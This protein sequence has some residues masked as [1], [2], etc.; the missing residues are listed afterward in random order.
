MPLCFDSKHGPACPQV[1]PDG[2]PGV[3]KGGETR[4]QEWWVRVCEE[5][6][7]LAQKCSLEMHA[8]GVIFLACCLGVIQND[9]E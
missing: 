6:S 7:S 1:L 8:T 9:S 2:A 4:R 5:K 3:K